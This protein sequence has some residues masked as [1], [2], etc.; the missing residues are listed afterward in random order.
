MLVISPQSLTITDVLS[1]YSALEDAQCRCGFS[2]RT[3][4]S[5]S[6]ECEF[7]YPVLTN[8]YVFTLNVIPTCGI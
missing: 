1:S 3:F 6:E 8:E 2:L 5:I 4:V 7:I